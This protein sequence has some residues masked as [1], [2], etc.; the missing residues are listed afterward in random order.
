MES[1]FTVKHCLYVL[2]YMYLSVVCGQLCF[3]LTCLPLF[4]TGEGEG[5]PF[6]PWCISTEKLSVTFAC[7]F[8]PCSSKHS[9]IAPAAEDHR[10]G[11][12]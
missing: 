6:S 5:L 8:L 2:I 9:Y 11:T 7:E 10:K 4:V 12:F 1:K 3:S